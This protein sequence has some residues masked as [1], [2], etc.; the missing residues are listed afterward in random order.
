MVLSAQVHLTITPHRSN[1]NKHTHTHTHISGL[2]P[3]YQQHWGAF[4]SGVELSLG[5]INWRERETAERERE[6]GGGGNT[7]AE[8]MGGTRVKLFL[9]VCVCLCLCVCVCVQMRSLSPLKCRRQCRWQWGCAYTHCTKQH[10]CTPTPQLCLKT[11]P[12]WVGVWCG[13]VFGGMALCCHGVDDGA[14]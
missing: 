7:G 6:G 10:R 11:K 2:K 4:A 13:V 14:V 8:R 9:C 3:V 5:G 1:T 12:R